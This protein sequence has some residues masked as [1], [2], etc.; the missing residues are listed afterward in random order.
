MSSSAQY[1]PEIIVN[2]VLGLPATELE[3]A[4]VEACTQFPELCNFLATKLKPE[5]VSTAFVTFFFWLSNFA[6]KTRFWAKM[7]RFFFLF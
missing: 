2:E 1:D 5:K 7:I 4:M 3:R 6:Q